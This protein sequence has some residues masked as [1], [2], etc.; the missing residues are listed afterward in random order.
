M[1]RVTGPIRIPDDWR[2]MA[3]LVAALAAI[4]LRVLIPA[5]FMLATDARA[6]GV[7]ITICTGDGVHAARLGADGTITVDNG[8]ASGEPQD[9]D[10]AK[11]GSCTFAGAA[12]AVPSPPASAL[13]APLAA[14]KQTYATFVLRD[15]VPGRGLAAPPPPSTA[16]PVSL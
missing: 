14:A 9:S 15:L 1:G 2:R 5:G 16:P 10:G 4:M 3:A 8:T 7:I 12:T 11:H 6:E 13:A